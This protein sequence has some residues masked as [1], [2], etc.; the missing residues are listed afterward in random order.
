MINRLEDLQAHLHRHTFDEL[1]DHAAADALARFLPGV[2]LEVS[3][4]SHQAVTVERGLRHLPAHGASYRELYLGPP[5]PLQL[6]TS[7]AGSEPREAIL[8]DLYFRNL[9]SALQR[10]GYQQELVRAGRSD[11]LSGLPGQHALERAI[12]ETQSRQLMLGTVALDEGGTSASRTDESAMQMRNFARLVRNELLEDERAYRLRNDRIALLIPVTE[13][14]RYAELLSRH[15][16]TAL[17]GWAELS[18]APGAEVLKL[19]EA[20]LL[21]QASAPAAPLAA[22]ASPRLPHELRV[23]AGSAQV[24]QLARGQLGTWRFRVP[25]TLVLDSP[26]GFALEV[27]P[28]VDGRYLVVTRSRSR[29]YLLD[30]LERKPQGLV[31]EPDS[32]SMLR[33]QLQRVAAGEEVYSGPL[34]KDNLLPRERTVWRLVA[35][36][37]DN[38]QVAARMRVSAKTV[39]NYLSSLQTKLGHSNQAALVN[40]YWDEPEQ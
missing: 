8:L 2:S 25:V 22:T 15:A 30:L 13:Q 36:G 38:S 32:L 33:S 24:R 1:R 21:G 35:R 18:E 20:R 31:T 10:A 11:W 14:S 34:L 6:T 26:V 39:A 17:C 37:L 12:H 9:L 27:L 29:G 4:V 40:A 7:G 28:E 5:E 3:P 19:V 23:Q 16:P